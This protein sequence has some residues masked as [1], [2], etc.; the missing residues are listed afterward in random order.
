[1]LPVGVNGDTGVETARRQGSEPREQRGALA[2]VC[3][4]SQR[5]GSRPACFRQRI[6]G[7]TVVHQPDWQGHACLGSRFTNAT[8]DTE[9]GALGL[10]R[11]N[12]DGDVQRIARLT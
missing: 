12:E 8:D 1:M 2:L 4:V 10:V 9:H 5:V 7:G 6:V 11:W 3:S